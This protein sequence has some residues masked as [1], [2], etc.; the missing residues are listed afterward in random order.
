MWFTGEFLR[1]RQWLDGL[2]GDAVRLSPAC[3]AGGRRFSRPRPRTGPSLCMVRWR[4]AVF[5]CKT[6]HESES[7][8]TRHAGGRRPR[9]VGA[10]RP[11]A[12]L[13][14]EGRPARRVVGR[15]SATVR[16]SIRC[17]LRC[18][19]CWRCCLWSPRFWVPR[20]VIAVNG[21]SPV[22][23]N[24][25]APHLLWSSPARLD[26]AKPGRL[27]A[28]ADAARDPEPTPRMVLRTPSP[29]HRSGWPV[30]SRSRRGTGSRRNRQ[31]GR[32]GP[33]AAAPTGV[34]PPA[35]QLKSPTPT[36]PPRP[37]PTPART[38]ASSLAVP[39]AWAPSAGSRFPRAP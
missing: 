34:S 1:L 28:P 27:A 14:D 3:R 25:A 24:Q 37:R 13:L 8:R 7:L 23:R 31:P 20:R 19:A 12:G 21:T 36:P 22:W 11:L 38:R 33:A 17:C 5:A 15:R 30:A 16:L 26:T 6:T 4:V 39:A 29:R 9:L 10:L 18:A 35:R 32:T 2:A